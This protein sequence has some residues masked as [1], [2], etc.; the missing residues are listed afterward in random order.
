MPTP[1]VPM[2]KQRQILQLLHDAHLS[3][4]EIAAA[5]HVSKSSVSDIARAARLAGLDWEA[6]NK[7]NDDELNARIYR[8]GTVRKSALIEPDYSYLYRE[9]K[10]TGVTLQLL[11]EEYQGQHGS[12]AYKYSAFCDRFRQ[13]SKTLKLSMR[14]IHPAGERAF[15]DF[16]GPTVPI[17]DTHTGEI[18]QAQIFVAILGASSYTFACATRAQKVQNWVQCTIAALEYFG[19]VPR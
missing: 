8:P 14:Q 13:W 4:R 15:L 6:A 1:K 7:L 2:S 10:R 11:W 3:T 16:A 12:N 9:L 5:V 17:I 19:G 18:T